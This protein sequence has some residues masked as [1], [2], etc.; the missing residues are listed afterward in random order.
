MD[1]SLYACI[2]FG[3]FGTFREK[4]GLS[5]ASGAELKLKKKSDHLCLLSLAYVASVVGVYARVLAL[6][7][8]H[9]DYT[10]QGRWQK[11]FFW[12]I[13]ALPGMLSLYLYDQYERYCMRL[14]PLPKP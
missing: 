1:L 13:E 9:I 7:R 5:L 6:H 4:M 3:I 2:Y 8:G 14:A 12:S 10:V 11:V